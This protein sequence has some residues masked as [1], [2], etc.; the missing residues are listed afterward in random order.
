MGDSVSFDITKDHA[1][2]FALILSSGVPHMD[3]I[4][5]LRP[6]VSG[7]QLK[8]ELKRW[9][10]APVVA[11]AILQVQGKSWQKMELSERV[12]FAID[13]NYTEMA[14]FLYSHNYCDLSG[15]EKSKADTC[16]AA[17]EAKL[18]GLAGKMDALS[19]WWDDVMSGKT[20]L[21]AENAPKRT[22]AP[23]S[24]MGQA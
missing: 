11:A 16:R 17:L 9:L 21:G 18:A 2:Q 7:D 6:D 20:S 3:A 24:Q 19:H 5:Y 23:G 10:A 12:K 15:P 14:Y 8:N 1:L 13:K 4:S 22:P